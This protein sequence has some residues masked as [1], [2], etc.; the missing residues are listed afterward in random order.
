MTHV[1][2]ATLRTADAAETRAF[3]A[4]VPA[5]QLVAAV[6]ETSDAELTA[7]IDRDE[8]R[9]AAVE[10]VLGRLHEYALLERL[11]ELVGTVR[12]DLVRG[13]TVRERHGLVL[14]HGTLK[15]L[16]DLPVSEP[17]DVVLRTSVVGFVRLISGEANPGLDYLAGRLRIEGDAMLALAVGGMFTVPGTDA[18]ALDPT[19]LDPTDVATALKGVSAE[20]LRE[21]M[22][23]GFRGVVLDEIFRR[24]PDFVSR[25]RAARCDLLIGF[26]L[27]GHP[28]GEIERYV[29]RVRHGVAEVTPGDA[30]RAGERRDA[31]ITCEGSDFLRLATGHLSAITGVL[32]GQ[33]KVKGDRGKALQFAGVLD[34]PSAR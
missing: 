12:F 32:R 4:D 13:G 30:E 33:L 1:T 5:E 25:R 2:L 34:I 21:V 8:I 3:L 31:T 19:T 26:R 17:V 16:P 14:D 29:V 24:L 7:I 27:L 6:R 20:H 22:A 18:V 9:G 10:G 15:V 28:S 23:S 11:A